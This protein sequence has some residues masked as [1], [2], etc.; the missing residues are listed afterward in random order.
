MST[1][2]GVRRLLLDAAPGE[3]RGVVLL[4]GRPERLLLERDGEADPAPLGA[5]LVGRLAAWAGERAFVD[6]P[7]GPAGLLRPPPGVRLAEGAALEVE[8]VA[9]AYGDKGPRLRWMATAE[10]PPRPLAPAPPLEER[11]RDLASGTP[12]ETG[13]E[14]REAA[15]LAQE[16]VLAVEHR[17]RGGLTLFV[18]STRALTAVDV[19][20]AAGDAA[21]ERRLREANLSA[22]RHAVRLLRLK[23]LGG[24]AA[25]DLLG[26]P[27]EDQRGLLRAEAARALTPDGEG[28]VAAAP[29]RFGLLHLSRPR[30]ERPLAERLLDAAGAPSAR[31]VAQ[32]LVRDFEREGRADPGGRFLVLAPP[33]VIAAL[34]PVI[35]RLGPRLALKAMAIARHDAHIA[36]A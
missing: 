18:E 31:T 28:A 21:G 34:A 35:E 25:L 23:G 30:R 24:V 11:L 14:A 32:R 4:D 1:P 27:A 8:V 20:L 6:L 9:E 19:D 16:A 26:F 13:P 17:F 15:D 12:V 2:G 7:A 3:R 33:D 36:P 22:I 10:G 29:D 5:R